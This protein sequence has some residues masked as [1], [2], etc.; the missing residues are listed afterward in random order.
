MTMSENKLLGHNYIR[1]GL[2]T[3]MNMSAPC[4]SIQ[5][6]QASILFFRCPG[7]IQMGLPLYCYKSIE[8]ASKN[9][10]CNVGI[11]FYI[12]QLS[13]QRYRSI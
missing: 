4:Q 5:S 7:R 11:P 13:F 12:R 8:D 3:P 6:S 1:F 10:S 2:L 9:R